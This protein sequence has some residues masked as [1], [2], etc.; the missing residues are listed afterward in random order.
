MHLK[1]HFV[2]ENKTFFIY[3]LAIS[4]ILHLIF[5]FSTSNLS[6]LLKPELNFS[7]YGTKESNY[8]IEIDLEPDEQKEKTVEEE[9]GIEADVRE[10]RRQLFV[11]TSGRA[12]DEETQ[13]ET[14]KIG[15]KGSVARDMY[16][17]ENN[18]NDKPRLESESDFPGDAPAEFASTVPQDFGMPIDVSP[19][20]PVKDEAEEAVE[21]SVKEE[22]AAVLIEVGKSEVLPV[23]D[24]VEKR[25]VAKEE[26]VV[27]DVKPEES[28][29]EEVVSAVL[30]S[31]VVL[32]E[33]E[34]KEAD[35]TDAVVV[36]EETEKTTDLVEE[37]TETESI[38][39][40]LMK[41]VVEG[42]RDSV[43]KKLQNK[44]KSSE[45]QVNNVPPGDDAPF[46]E[47]SI[48]NAPLRGVESFNVKKHEYAPYYKH[49]KDKIRLYWLLQ[50]GTDA[51]INQVTKGYKPIVVTFKVFPSGKIKN[52]EIADTAGN[53][54]LASKIKVSIK[55]TTLDKFPDYINEKHI[56][57][58]FSYFFY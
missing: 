6:S 55:N 52:V 4:G 28:S 54:L 56:D 40:M 10:E 29:V 24:E 33:S 31:D 26:P 22:A 21:E 43:A 30:G 13:A 12:V 49:I 3:F 50:Y 48:S 15:E 23:S 53:E 58:K 2:Y 51:S 38:S 20:E 37:Y 41:E 36:E 14:N 19:S 45:R 42:R 39:K 17:G 5:I 57:V 35:D 11:D 47:D 9:D 46:F 25:D 44:N 16:S 8:V 1:P 18:I 32:L 7:D 27:K 34:S